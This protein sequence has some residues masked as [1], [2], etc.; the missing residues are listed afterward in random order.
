[1]ND[2]VVVQTEAETEQS[3][4]PEVEIEA[5]QGENTPQAEEPKTFTQ[6]DV[7]RIAQKERSKAERRAAREYQVKLESIAKQS[8]PVQHQASANSDEPQL[9]NFEK[10][11]DYVKAVARY[12]MEQDKKAAQQAQAE[13]RQVE[14]SVK[15]QQIF[16]EA[17]KIQGFDRDAFDELTVSNA[18]AEAIMDSDKAP[19]LVAHLAANP[20][21]A[22]RIAKLTP[23]RQAA[24]IGKLEVKLQDAAKVKVSKAPSPINPLGNRGGAAISN[25]AEAKNMDDYE[26]MRRKQGAK[27]HR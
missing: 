15:V 18:M 26:A 12:E 13:S 5:I 6:E 19:Q 16:E 9:E 8:Q 14:A 3:A 20:N 25:L 27:W 7:D 1:M 24:E 22:D 17:E 11:Q 2:E 21:D 4:T 10:V 23:A